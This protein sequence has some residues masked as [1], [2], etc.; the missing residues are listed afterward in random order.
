MIPLCRIQVQAAIETTT[1]TLIEH[2]AGDWARSQES[3]QRSTTGNGAEQADD[4]PM[5]LIA[6]VFRVLP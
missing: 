5:N 1:T 2:L 6:N 4:R 3:K